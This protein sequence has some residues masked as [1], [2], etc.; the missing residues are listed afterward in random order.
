[1][2]IPNF[3]PSCFNTYE[4]DTNTFLPSYEHIIVNGSSFY[5]NAYKH[6]DKVNIVNTLSSHYSGTY[7][8][9][10]VKSTYANIQSFSNMLTESNIETQPESADNGIFD[11][12]YKDNEHKYN[13]NEYNER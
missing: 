8:Y 11:N 1:N 2:I 6:Y 7:E 10:S 9:D 3:S 13:E 12:K 4:L 5:P